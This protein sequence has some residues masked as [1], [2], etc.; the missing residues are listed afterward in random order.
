MEEVINKVIEAGAQAPSGGNSQPWRFEI[1]KN[2]IFIFALPERDHPILNFRHRGTLIAIGALL[3]NMDIAAHTMQKK[4]NIQFYPN[5]EQQM[6]IARVE[7]L[8]LDIFISDSLYDAI[9]NRNTNRKPFIPETLLIEQ[10]E[11]LYNIRDESRKIKIS[12]IEDAARIKFLGEAVSK[13]EIVMFENKKL[14]RLFFNE[15]VWTR[16]EERK[17]GKGLFIKTLEMKPLDEKAMKILKHWP[18]MKIANKFGMARKIARQNSITYASASLVGVISLRDNDEDFIQAGRIMER[19]WL[20]AT[21]LGLSFHLITGILFLWQRIRAGEKD[22]FSKKH[23]KIIEQ[24]YAAIRDTFQINEGIITLF[25]RIGRSEP[26][27][28]Y[29]YKNT[30]F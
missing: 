30:K 18:V 2:V 10:K 4:L 28:A 14:H 3:E 15:V 17:K 13:N 26:P 22:F 25:F 29:S 8:P 16:E 27:S 9:K 6:L 11:D 23:I 19:L 5:E 1:Q 24:A 12:W 20:T 7:L 21:K